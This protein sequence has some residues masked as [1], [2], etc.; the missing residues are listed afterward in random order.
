M[1]IVSM[2]ATGAV[3]ILALSGALSASPASAASYVPA[4]LTRASDAG[5]ANSGADQCLYSRFGCP[6]VHK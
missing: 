2:I 5:H 4:S 1:K 3:V 6:V